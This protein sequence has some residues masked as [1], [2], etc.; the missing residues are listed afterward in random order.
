MHVTGV[1]VLRAGQHGVILRRA[2]RN[3]WDIGG[4]KAPAEAVVG[5]VDDDVLPLGIEAGN[6]AR[7]RFGRDCSGRA[8]DIGRIGQA[9]HGRARGLYEHVGHGYLEDESESRRGGCV[10]TVRQRRKGQ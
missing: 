3:E 6:L 9:R 10:A 7:G 2:K 5:T 8:R 1:C 4:R